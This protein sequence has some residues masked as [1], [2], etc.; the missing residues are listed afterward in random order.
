M[1]AR[2][3]GPRLSLWASSCRN[4]D[5][6]ESFPTSREE[7]VP[8]HKGSRGGSRAPPGCG[9]GLCAAEPEAEGMW[10]ELWGAV[11]CQ[12]RWEVPEDR[13]G[14][15]LQERL[16]QVVHHALGGGTYGFSGIAA[17]SPTHRD[18]WFPLLASGRGCSHVELLWWPLSSCRG[19][20]PWS[21][22][23]SGPEPA[24]FLSSAHGS[25]RHF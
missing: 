2:P 13:S 14:Q 11:G 10:E 3:W 20:A 19:A 8:H 7:K 9:P 16:S 6:Q 5:R 21:L 12:D 25:W 15:P 17:W 23:W 4:L 22:V 1:V 24:E 18:L